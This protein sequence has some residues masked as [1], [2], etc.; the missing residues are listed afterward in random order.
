[1]CITTFIGI[2]PSS[3]RGFEN[4]HPDDV[5]TLVQVAL[6]KCLQKEALCNEFYLQL[7]KQTTEQPGKGG[8]E[9]EKERKIIEKD[10][11]R[12]KKYNV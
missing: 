6:E 4:V 12:N 10:I 8:N 5:M 1:M 3:G 9:K 2:T 7:I 11:G